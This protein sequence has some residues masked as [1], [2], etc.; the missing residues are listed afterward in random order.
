MNDVCAC[1]CMLNKNS[2]TASV[3]NTLL[4][5]SILDHDNLANCNSSVGTMIL[6]LFM[7]MRNPLIGNNFSLDGCINLC[8]WVYMTWSS[9]ASRFLML[10]FLLIGAA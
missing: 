5:C 8:Y 6:I 4:I 2:C 10:R 1:A 9:I 3:I 7:S